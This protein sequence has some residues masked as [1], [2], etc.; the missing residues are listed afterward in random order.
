MLNVSQIL[1][2]SVVVLRRQAPR[3]RV[4][5]WGRDFTAVNVPLRTTL[6]QHADPVSLKDAR[7]VL[8]SDNNLMDALRLV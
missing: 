3:A 4:I 7:G 5:S 1:G 6:L 2:D 8:M